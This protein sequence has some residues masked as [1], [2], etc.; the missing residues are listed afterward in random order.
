MVGYTEG[1]WEAAPPAPDCDAP[2]IFCGSRLIG[3]ASN[4]DMPR[5]EK[6]ANARLM[7]AAPEMLRALVQLLAEAE[8]LRESYSES[9]KFEG[10]DAVEEEPCFALAREAIAKAMPPN[11]ELCGGPSGPSERAP[12]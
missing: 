8:S 6:E 1:I 7:A 3:F 2:R 9:R 12:G 11:A 4:S 5:D 10:W